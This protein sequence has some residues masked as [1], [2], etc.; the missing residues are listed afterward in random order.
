MAIQRDE[1]ERLCSKLNTLERSFTELR[2]DIRR[3]SGGPRRTTGDSESSAA[4]LKEESPEPDGPRYVRAMEINE[5]SQMTGER[6]HLG[7]G[8]VPALV[9]AL[10]KLN[11]TEAMRDVLG[12]NVLPLFGL[13]NETATYPFVDL[14]AQPKGNLDRITE[15]CKALPSD[16]E[17]LE[18]VQLPPKAMVSCPYIHHGS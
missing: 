5:Q 15:L 12:N 10:R 2:D 4:G 9:L 1:W 3:I 18:Y 14:W 6:V 8:S 17:C 13:D 16:A 7:G 11:N